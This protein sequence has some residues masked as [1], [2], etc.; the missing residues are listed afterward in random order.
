VFSATRAFILDLDGTLVDTAADLSIA[1]NAMLADLGL[2]PVSPEKVSGWIGRGAEV[3]VHRALSGCR[4]GRVDT[5][6]ARTGLDRFLFHYERENGRSARVYPGVVEGLEG[7]RALGLRL[8]CV[9]NK[10]ARF[11]GSLLE[12]TG[13]SACFEEWVGGDD[14]PRRK[15]DPLPFLWIASRLA[16]NPASIVAVGDSLNDS[17]AARASGMG[18]ILVRYG[19]SEGRPLQR[20]DADLFVDSLAEI[21]DLLRAGKDSAM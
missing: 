18:I 12:A 21:P 5:D 11:A 9:T 17:M 8:A 20:G 14:L 6:R 13:L 4:D 19:Y 2:D 7:L 10:P 15:P 3:L 16:L 1:V